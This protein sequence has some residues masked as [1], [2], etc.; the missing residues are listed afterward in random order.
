M[1]EEDYSFTDEDE[2]IIEEAVTIAELFCE[3][4]EMMEEQHTRLLE[5][6]STDS[7]LAAHDLQ[8]VIKYFKARLGIEDADL[9]LLYGADPDRVLH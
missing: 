9:E 6:N 8:C 2:M 5:K 7:V 1:S 4:L 3:E